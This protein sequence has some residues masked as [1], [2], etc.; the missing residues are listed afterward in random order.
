MS[1]NYPQQGQGQMSNDYAQSEQGQG[2]SSPMQGQ[3][4]ASYDLPQQM[5]RQRISQ[6]S[7]SYSRSQS[8]PLSKSKLRRRENLHICHPLEQL[9]QLSHANLLGV[10]DVFYCERMKCFCIVYAVEKNTVPLSSFIANR[11]KKLGLDEI[12]IIMKQLAKGFEFLDQNSVYVHQFN[13]EDIF[14]TIDEFT[15]ELIAE[16]RYIK[17]G[18]RQDLYHIYVPP[19]SYFPK[20]INRDQF[21]TK[22]LKSFRLSWQL[23]I[24]LIELLRGQQFSSWYT[25]EE[26]IQTVDLICNYLNNPKIK[27]TFKISNFITEVLLGMT[28]VG[29]DERW[30]F[31]KIYEHFQIEYSPF[32]Q[33][34]FLDREDNF[35]MLVRSELKA[36]FCDDLE[37]ENNGKNSN[38]EAQMKEVIDT[39]VQFYEEARALQKQNNG[40]RRMRS[41]R[42]S[43]SEC[44]LQVIQGKNFEGLL[45]GHLQK[46]SIIND[47]SQNDSM[48]SEDTTDKS[49]TECG[50]LP[51]FDTPTRDQNFSQS[52]KPQP[53][54]KI[55]AFFTS[56]TQLFKHP[57][58]QY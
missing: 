12:Q 25:Q 49:P 36:C 26:Y 37:E 40:N 22:Q 57:P 6:R 33:K 56:I 20:L 2:L 16:I 3:R 28:A 10:Q 31:N 32:E 58:N 53:L 30:E 4:R 1:S 8:F 50:D 29:L 39:Y 43:L 11:T 9:L 24:L 51:T 19:E 54:D 47:P 5:Q 42:L 23:G 27:N 34:R 21:T 17:L 35:L 52:S 46:L 38:R 13:M 15:G 44:Y 45:Q 18:Y 7:Q 55:C 41:R 14:I 48:F